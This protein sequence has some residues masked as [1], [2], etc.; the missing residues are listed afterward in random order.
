MP[1]SGLLLSTMY[2]FV[3]TIVRKVQAMLQASGRHDVVLNIVFPAASEAIT[4][5]S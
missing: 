3:T 4:T 2:L 1:C 5:D